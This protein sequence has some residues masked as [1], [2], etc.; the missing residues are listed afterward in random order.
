MKQETL[1]KLVYLV[2]NADDA[3]VRIIINAL[4]RRAKVNRQMRTDEMRSKL[5]LTDEVRLKNMKPKYLNGTRGS[6]IGFEAGNKVRIRFADNV[7][8]RALRRW[9]WEPLIHIS[10][11][12]L[13]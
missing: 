3:E 8:P 5:Q 7:D 4:N 6:V 12:E 9:G 1:K 2:E 13:V 11:L 10:A